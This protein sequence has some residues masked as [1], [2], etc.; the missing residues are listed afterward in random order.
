MGL[1][2]T[3][4]CL[5]QGIEKLK[6]H[7]EERRK[8]NFAANLIQANYETALLHARIEGKILFELD[9]SRYNFLLPKLWVKSLWDF[10]SRFKI[11]TPKN[12]WT[13]H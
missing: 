8:A 4:L 7:V 5:V 2:F 6:L 10:L 13:Y 1:G 11:T 9:Y 12:K 3:N